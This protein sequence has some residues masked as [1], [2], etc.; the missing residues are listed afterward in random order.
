MQILK[1]GYKGTILSEKRKVKS[2]KYF[3]RAND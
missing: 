1:L 2:E 3:V